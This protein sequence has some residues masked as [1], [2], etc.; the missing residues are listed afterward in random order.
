MDTTQATL[1]PSKE[2]QRLSQKLVGKALLSGGVTGTSHCELMEGGFFLLQHIDI[3]QNGMHIKGIEIIG[4]LK[5]F[6]AEPTAEIHSRFYD[7]NG[8]TLDYTYELS[9]DGQKLT[10]WGGEKG[11]PAY[12]EGIFNDDGTCN[13]EWH[14]PGGGGYKMTTKPVKG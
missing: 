3:T 11:S 4:H 7:N 8:N 10:V 9:E 14:Y 6:G 13:G 5:A 12:Y 1:T 2:M